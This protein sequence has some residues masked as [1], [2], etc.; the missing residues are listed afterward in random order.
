LSNT[1]SF[2]FLQ[3]AIG[4]APELSG[5]CCV[6]LFTHPLTEMDDDSTRTRKRHY[7]DKEPKDRSSK[8]KGSK[9]HRRDDDEDDHKRHKD[10]RTKD[11]QPG[12]KV[13]DDDEDGQEVW[14]EKNIDQ[15]AEMVRKH[16]VHKSYGSRLIASL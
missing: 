2:T 1:V 7:G 6:R 13:V 16:Q 11:K 12:V 8:S 4:K 9:R 14:V 15:D 5:A 10:R 3:N